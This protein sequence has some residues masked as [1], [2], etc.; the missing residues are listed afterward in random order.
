MQTSTS[1]LP[2]KAYQ[3][4]PSQGSKIVILILSNAGFIGM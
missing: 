1:E 2:K 4:A 3:I